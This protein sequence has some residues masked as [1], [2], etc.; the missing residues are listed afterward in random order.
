MKLIKTILPLALLLLASTACNKKLFGI[1]G[2]GNNVTEVRSLNGFNKIDLDI[3][4]DVTYQQSATFYVEISAQSNILEVLRTDISAGVLKIDFRKWVRRHSNISI[5]IHSPEI[6][7]I[8]I[9]GSGN[10][11]VPTAITTTDMELRISG[12]GNLTLYSLTTA[13]LDASISGSGNLEVLNGTVNNQAATISGSGDIDMEH[14]Q[15]NNSASKI[16]GSGSITVHVIQE[17]DAT[18]SGSGN[19]RYRGTP[20]VNANI[21]G[22]GSV[23]HI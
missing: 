1:K 4:A 18:I 17:L 3:D 19:I 22:S 10:V 7:G 13:D 15:A 20:A 12:S 8:K 11:N 21:S 16:S 6:K 23:I 14:C 5:V 2:K 9:S